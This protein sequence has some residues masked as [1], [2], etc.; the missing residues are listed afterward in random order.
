[1]RH[2]RS[3][4]ESAYERQSVAHR[5]TLE[6]SSIVPNLHS[7]NC[8]NACFLHT[9]N[10]RLIKASQGGPAWSV[11][12]KPGTHH[13]EMLQ[14][15]SSLAGLYHRVL[16]CVEKH[17]FRAVSRSEGLHDGLNF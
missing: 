16:L 6:V 14:A 11:T 10:T 5:A 3:A 15:G 13:V 4:H 8:A 17:A 7:A 9:S 2:P 12:R 1:M